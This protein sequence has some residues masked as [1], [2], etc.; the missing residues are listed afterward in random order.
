VF[1]CAC[2]CV[3]ACACAYVCVSV[4]EGGGGGVPY[5][6]LRGRRP[7]L[8][9]LFLSFHDPRYLDVKVYDCSGCVCI[10]CACTR[11]CVHV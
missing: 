11:V 5:F 6:V 4:H 8:A 7:S 2:V 1:R 10:V 9:S 3:C